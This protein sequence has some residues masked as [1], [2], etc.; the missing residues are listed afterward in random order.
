MEKN[1]CRTG[2]CTWKAQRSHSLQEMGRRVWKGKIQYTCDLS[3]LLRNV[4]IRSVII[5]GQ[6]SISLVNDKW[7]LDSLVNTFLSISM[8]SN[9]RT[10][11]TNIN[12]ILAVI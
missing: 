12:C 8:L 5:T 2:F 9:C 1:I 11:E 6:G 7:L 3:I 10:P 4:T